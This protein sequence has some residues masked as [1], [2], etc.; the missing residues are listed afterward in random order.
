MAEVAP[1]HAGDS[2]MASRVCSAKK[3]E[4][5]DYNEVGFTVDSCEQNGR[6]LRKFVLVKVTMHLLL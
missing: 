4:R 3:N 6:K 1:V 5:G 2:E